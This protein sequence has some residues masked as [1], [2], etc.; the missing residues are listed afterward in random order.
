MINRIA[1]KGDVFK[2]ACTRWLLGTRVRRFGCRGLDFGAPPHWC[3]TCAAPRIGVKTKPFADAVELKQ[4][5]LGLSMK[6]D[7]PEQV[8]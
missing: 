5:E 7:Q 2:G 4:G 8:R 3:R 6:V 1:V